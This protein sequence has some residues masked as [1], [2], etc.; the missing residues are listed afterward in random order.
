MSARGLVAVESSNISYFVTR[1]LTGIFVIIIILLIAYCILNIY[2]LQVIML[3]AMII[4]AAFVAGFL[5][6]D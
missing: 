5:I 4:G 2:F 1:V 6:M 3:L